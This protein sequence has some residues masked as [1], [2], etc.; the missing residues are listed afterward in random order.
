MDATR[1]IHNADEKTWTIRN[2]TDM[3]NVSND[4]MTL[5]KVLK[6]QLHYMIPKRFKS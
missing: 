1:K 5:A 3:S 4:G 2:Q 6:N